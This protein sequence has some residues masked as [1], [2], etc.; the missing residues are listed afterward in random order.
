MKKDLRSAYCLLLFSLITLTAACSDITK[1]LSGSARP[2]AAVAEQVPPTKNFNAPYD[3]T[4]KA[5][6]NVFDN[7]GVLYEADKTNGKI[8]TEDKLLQN[9]SG[10]RAMFAGSNYKAKQFI[11]V[12]KTADNQTSVKFSARFTKEFMTIL[13]TTNKE[14][15]EAENMLRKT[16]F[17]ELDQ[18]LASLPPPV[19]QKASSKDIGNFCKAV[20][21]CNVRPEPST[22][23][24]PIA[25]LQV[26]DTAEKI[27]QQGDWI[28][29]RLD[30]GREGWVNKSLVE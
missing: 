29:I 5:A 26:G 12:K 24:T 18:Q 30:D 10:W 15:P 6:L 2:D 25:Q 28:K 22:K 14:Y 16:F 20:K 11:D 23:N 8:V 3:M 21:T 7:N 1:E 19:T 17:D 4:W 13:P 27:T 9:I